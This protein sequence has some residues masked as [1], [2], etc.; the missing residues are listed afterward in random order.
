MTLKSTKLTATALAL[1]GIMG[2][3]Q[4]FAKPSKEDIEGAL[5][6]LGVAALAHNENH[7]QAGREPSGAQDTA[8]FE[9][10]YRDGLHNYD[11]NAGSSAYAY[12]DGYSAGMKEREN[13]AAPRRAHAAGTTGTVP[14]DVL[15]GCA[16]AVADA[17]GVGIHDVQIV[18]SE[19]QA[20]NVFLVEAA[21]GHKHMSCVMDGVG[22]P[23]SVVDGHI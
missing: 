4:A 13:R 12:G 22:V 2:A 20:E 9:R 6:L 15:R 11:Y 7:Y 23:Q 14:H 19:K 3:T 1:I 17:L 10:G 8:D 21:V 16:G 18:A 5:L